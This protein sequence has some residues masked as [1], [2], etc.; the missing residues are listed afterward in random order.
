M[1]IAAE[2]SLD[3]DDEYCEHGR[4]ICA[5]CDVEYDD[6]FEDEDDDYDEEC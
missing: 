4:L 5:L 6:N 1:S 3:V 2:E